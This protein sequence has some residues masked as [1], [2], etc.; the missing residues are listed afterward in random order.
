MVDGREHDS[1][2]SAIRQDPEFTVAV[3]EGILAER[4]QVAVQLAA[5]QLA[6]WAHRDGI[7]VVEAARWLLATGCLP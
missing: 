6:H 1:I 2:F 7:P 3:A 4:Y 5:R